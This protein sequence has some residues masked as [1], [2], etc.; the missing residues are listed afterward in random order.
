VHNASLR[1][2]ESKV[3]KGYLGLPGNIHGGPFPHV[4]TAAKKSL[5]RTLTVK[6]DPRCKVI[7]DVDLPIQDFQRPASEREV[8]KAFRRIF[9]AL[10]KGDDVYIGCT[11]GWGRTGTIMASLVNVARPDVDPVEFVR[12]YYDP[13]AVETK[14][15]ADYARTFADRHPWFARWVRFWYL[16]D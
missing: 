7:P 10:S 16:T 2:V 12:R 3:L 11:A 8:M 15:Q 5:N 13:S 9:S 14:A 4:A 1:T 6:L